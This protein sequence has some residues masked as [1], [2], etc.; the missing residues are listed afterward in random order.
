MYLHSWSLSEFSLVGTI[1]SVGAIEAAL[2]SDFQNGPRGIT[3]QKL[4]GFTGAEASDVSAPMLTEA[5]VQD[6]RQMLVR[7]PKFICQSGQGKVGGDVFRGVLQDGS[8]EVG[9]P[10]FLLLFERHLQG[11]GRQQN[12]DNALKSFQRFVRIRGIFMFFAEII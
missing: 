11:D 1:E 4:V 12:F 3:F 8:N 7:I 6:A 2:S 10:V 5:M 9:L